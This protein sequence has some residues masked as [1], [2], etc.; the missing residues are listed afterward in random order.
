M[1]KKIKLGDTVRCKYTGFVGIAIAKTE[2][3]NGCVQID[4][5]PK[6][7]KDNK[8][9]E[10]QG[11]DVGSLEIIDKPKK[12]IQK[13]KTGGSNSLSKTQRGY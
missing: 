3:I 2:F 5:T 12:K 6:A 13:K 10:T 11:I 4:V 8:V 9:E 1:D 7:N